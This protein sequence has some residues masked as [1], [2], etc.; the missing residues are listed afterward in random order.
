MAWKVFQKKTWMQE[1]DFSNRKHGRVKERSKEMILMDT[2]R[3]RTLQLQLHFSRSPMSPQGH[4]QDH[5]VQEASRRTSTSQ[6]LLP[7]AGM[8]L[9]RGIREDTPVLLW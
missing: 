9:D 1:G 2:M 5:L 7:D 4:G 6:G 8:P 3:G